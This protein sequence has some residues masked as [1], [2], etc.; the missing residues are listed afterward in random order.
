MPIYDYKCLKCGKVSEVLVNNSVSQVIRCSECGSEDIEK[1]ISASYLI[2]MNKTV[3]GTTCCGRQE[4]CS[5]PPCESSN[6]CARG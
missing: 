3:V 2:K 4:R 1:L 5:S 6:I